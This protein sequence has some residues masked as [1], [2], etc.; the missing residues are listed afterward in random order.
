MAATMHDSRITRICAVIA[1]ALA[2]MFGMPSAASAAQRQGALSL[3]CVTEH[4]GAAVVLAGDTYALALVATA[5][6]T[7]NGGAP[8][9]TFEPAAGFEAY[10]Y[11]WGSLDANELRA[12]AHELDEHAQT[13][14]LYT[15]GTSTANQTGVASFG[16]LDPGLYLVNRVSVA[17]DNEAYTCDPMLI[18]VPALE[19]GAL[20][21]QV[22][23]EPKYEWSEPPVAPPSEPPTQGSEEP[24][25]P[26]LDDTLASWGLPT[27][28]DPA[29]RLGMGLMLLGV[30]LAAA[31]WWHRRRAAAL[32][33]GADSVTE[34]GDDVPA[35]ADSDCTVQ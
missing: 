19:D 20:V 34:A 14:G 18:S 9:V 27:T 23:A 31:G 35:H 15:A 26:T 28:G 16:W 1:V 2:C 30:S 12:A 13:A 6:V 24:S 7:W 32:V 4:D 11:S 25:A 22:V 5:D 3:Q 33:V 17:E 10:D 8:S 29:F 21:Y